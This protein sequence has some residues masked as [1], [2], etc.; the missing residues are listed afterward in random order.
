MAGCDVRHARERQV[1]DSQRPA[2]SPRAVAVPNYSSL[3][4]NGNTESPSRRFSAH[5]LQTYMLKFLI[6]SGVRERRAGLV[7]GAVKWRHNR[8]NLANNNVVRGG[9]QNRPCP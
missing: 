8:R 7:C 6:I 5:E 4:P 9:G 1:T 3:Y 2:L